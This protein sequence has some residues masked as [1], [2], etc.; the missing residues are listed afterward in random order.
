[1]WPKSDIAKLP[2]P[3]P[4]KLWNWLCIIL[5]VFALAILITLFFFSDSVNNNNTFFVVILVGITV[6]V[7][8]MLFGLRLFIY[9]LSEEKIA[10]WS[11]EIKLRDEK[12]QDWSMQSL[13][14]LGSVVITPQNLSTDDLLANQAEQSYSAHEVFAFSE[15]NKWFYLESYQWILSNLYD[16]LSQMDDGDTLTILQLNQHERRQDTEILIRR[17]YNELKLTLALEFQYIESNQEGPFNANQLIDNEEPA[18]YLVITDNTMDNDSS[19]FISALL[20]A[21]ESLAV[22]ILRSV[23]FDMTFSS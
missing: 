4:I 7:T 9:G 14:V 13:A 10:L 8:G 22:L 20:V 1:M 21:N 15:T 12:W 19:S 16:R 6:A 18:L 5:L 3:Q 11:E 23:S 17:A 2:P